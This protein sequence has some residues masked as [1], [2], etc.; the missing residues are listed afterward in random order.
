MLGR[1]SKYAYAGNKR[2]KGPAN[3]SNLEVEGD[4]GPER[5]RPVRWLR[6]I[7]RMGKVRMSSGDE[8]RACVRAAEVPLGG[9]LAIR[10]RDGQRL[11]PKTLGI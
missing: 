7:L 4:S 6:W 2:T 5:C 11:M 10:E 3:A 1:R 9:R 8:L